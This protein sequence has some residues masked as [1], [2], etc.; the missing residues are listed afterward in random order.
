MKKRQAGFIQNIALSIALRYSSL[1]IIG[2]LVSLTSVFYPVFLALT[3]YPADFLL[4]LFYSSTIIGD[5]I[6]L[7]NILIQLIPACLAVSA[8]F[9]L[10]ILNL[11]TPM[12]LKTRVRALAFSFLVLLLANIFRIFVFSILLLNNF[13]VFDF[14]H[15]FFWYFL[16]IFFVIAIWFLQVRIFKIKAIPAYT[17]IKT[18][19]N[20]SKR[21]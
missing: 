21:D 13:Q 20:I 6:I 15:K 14:L 17:D 12:P 2:L 11:A 10:L 8:Y 5:Y 4:S 16:S 1:L 3:I 9:L 19:Y 7:E 18:I